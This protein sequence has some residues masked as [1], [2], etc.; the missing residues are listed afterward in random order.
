M[1][2]PL[3]MIRPKIA[4][5]LEPSVLPAPN[6]LRE[7]GWGQMD[8]LSDILQDGRLGDII[9]NIQNRAQRTGFGQICV[10][11]RTFSPDLEHLTSNERRILSDLNSQPHQRVNSIYFKSECEK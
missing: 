9:S 8:T 5:G 4:Q 11:V 2:V 10:L 3:P 1:G 6:I 7:A